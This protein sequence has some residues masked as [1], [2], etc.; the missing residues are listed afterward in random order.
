MQQTC[1]VKRR[2][3]QTSVHGV[4]FCPGCLSRWSA[5]EGMQTRPMFSFQICSRFRKLKL[6]KTN[7][8]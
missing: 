8:V 6:L 5:L 3:L 4:H 1:A 7:L 2:N